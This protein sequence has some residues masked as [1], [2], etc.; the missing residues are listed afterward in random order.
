MTL[1]A[2]E[3]SLAVAAHPLDVVVTLRLRD[4]PADP[5]A[6]HISIMLALPPGATRPDLAQT[7]AAKPNPVTAVT[8]ALL[9]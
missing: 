7:E 1:P 3:N 2:E 8:D 9:F 5:S 6:V 4:P